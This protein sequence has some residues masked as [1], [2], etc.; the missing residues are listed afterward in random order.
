M[1]S[2]NGH[3]PKQ[4]ILYA[5]VST[6][7]QA[8]SGYSLAQQMEALREYA[9]REGYEV[10]EEVTDPGQSGASLER[11]GM[12][13]VRSLVITGRVKAVL[14]QDRDRFAREPAYHYLLHKEFEEHGCMIKA[15]NDRGDDSPEGELTDGI[16]DQIAKF[17]RDK[18]T[19]RTRRGKLRKAREGKIVANNSV[20]FGFEY[21]ATRDG[22]EI[23]EQTMPV[24]RRIFEMVASG[25][26]LNSIAE[27]L[28]REGV[29][30]PYSRSRSVKW[31]N[32]TFLRNC[33]VKDDV[34][35]PH[36]YEEIAALVTPE[37]AAK[38]D[39]RERYGVW[40][41]NRRKSK[42]TQVSVP[43]GNGRRYKR[44]TKYVSRP[45]EEWIAVPVPDS[46][47]PREVVDAARAVIKNNHAPSNAGRRFW[48]LSGGLV[49]CGLCGYYLKAHTVAKAGRPAYFYYT[50]R[51][52]HRK[53][54]EAC[55]NSKS[56]AA[57][58]VEALVWN[59]ISELLKD[60]EQLRADLDTMI[61]LERNSKGGDPDKETKLWAD[62]VDEVDRKRARYQ[63]MA[64]D[65]LLTLD[66]LRARLSDLDS[67]RAIA[68]KELE[69]LRNREEHVAELEK[70]RD[71]LLASLIS[72]APETL[73]A[74]TAEERRQVYVM[75]K[76]Q[77]YIY[78]DGSLEISGAFG[79][80]FDV[81][82]DETPSGPCS[83]LAT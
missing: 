39:P 21:N 31:W 33:I 3:S 49:R 11:P 30:V 40:W 74:L 69:A 14:A 66:E 54:A 12:D 34:Y 62:K 61:E 16:I 32:V 82:E 58:G 77:A 7:E 56:Q 50:C 79:E 51:T 37:V 23:D 8:R 38:L 64:A 24:V 15:L 68:E 76:L 48:E 59:A 35:R 42:T 63:E 20:D 75:L 5:R 2:T 43:D 1:P 65:D 72:I 29:R 73:D 18:T 17:E 83:A 4:A 28:S 25:S 52:K 53:G 46:G 70:N 55:S 78:P 9:A 57:D 67:T 19:E 47:V 36:T 81:C 41:F 10:L 44:R 22:Y 27:R 71:D 26:S 13:H 60:P 6:E 80:G 45:P